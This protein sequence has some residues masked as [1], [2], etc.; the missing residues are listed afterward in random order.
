MRRGAATARGDEVDPLILMLLLLLLFL[1]LLLLLLLL[2]SGRVRFRG[3]GRGRARRRSV[4][5]HVISKGEAICVKPQEVYK[6]SNMPAGRE[7]FLYV[8]GALFL[9]AG[10]LTSVQGSESAVSR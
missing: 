5:L 3:R 4:R 7:H 9:G 6:D 8:V 1:L 10:L 2:A